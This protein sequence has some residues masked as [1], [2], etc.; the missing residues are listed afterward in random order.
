MADMLRAM[1]VAPD[2]LAAATVHLVEGS[3]ALKALQG[4]ALAASGMAPQWHLTTATVPDGPALI[5]ANEFFDALPIRHYVRAADGWHEGL[6]ARMQAGRGAP[7]P[8]SHLSSLPS[9][10]RLALPTQSPPCSP[11]LLALSARLSALISPSRP[12]SSP[13]QASHRSSRTR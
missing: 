12:A 7:L 13:P 10:P 1:R 5:V 2:F 6:H 8:P 4:D 11:D 3:A 9:L